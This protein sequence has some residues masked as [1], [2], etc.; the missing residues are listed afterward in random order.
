M[1]LRSMPMEPS[2]TQH[3][4]TNTPKITRI[5]DGGRRNFAEMVRFA[6]TGSK[7][8]REGESQGREQPRDERRELVCRALSPKVSL[9]FTCGVVERHVDVR[10]LQQGAVTN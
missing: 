2:Q 3:A 1:R 10:Q 7:P 9:L 8:E 5:R 6:R 4:N